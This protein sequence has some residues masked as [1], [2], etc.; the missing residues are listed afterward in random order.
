MNIILIGFRCAGKTT[1]GQRL[2]EQIKAEFVDCD[3]YIEKKTHLTIR[4]IFDLCGESYFRMLEGDAIKEVCRADG[5]VIATGGGAALRYKNI[6]N[7]KQNGLVFFLDVGPEEA[8]KRITADPKTRSRR[9][10][11]TPKDLKSEVRE[12]VGLRRDY[13]LKA[14]DFTVRT[15]Q[16][17]A[18]EVVVE[19]VGRLK[20]RGLAEGGDDRDAS[21]A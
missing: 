8:T 19:I 7:L 9:P 16:R 11:L 18:E 6:H 21:L 1:V 15:D 3:D 17:S 2:A 13:Y 10:P 20:K 4:E 5:R 14:A 12:Q